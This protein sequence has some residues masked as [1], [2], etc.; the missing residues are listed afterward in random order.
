MGRGTLASS[1]SEQVCEVFSPCAAAALYRREALTEVGGFDEDYFCYME[2]VDLGFRLRL[3]GHCSL[4]VPQSI[5]HHVGS[6]VT[7]GQHGFQEPQQHVLQGH[8]RLVRAPMLVGRKVRGEH[9]V[10]KRRECSGEA[11]HPVI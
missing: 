5:A 8:E 4:Y 1:I 11:Q 9:R 6:G 10:G 2:D 7:G 3:A